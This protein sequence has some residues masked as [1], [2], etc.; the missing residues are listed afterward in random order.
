M[1]VGLYLI[2]NKEEN[3]MATN[4][5]IIYTGPVV[6]ADRVGQSIYRMFEP[7]GSYVDSNVF[8]NGYTNP[9]SVGDGNSYGKSVYATNVD[10][11]GSLPGLL[12]MASSV[13]RFA[14]FEQAIFAAKAAQDAGTT[15]E[16]I[17]FAVDGY[18][19]ELYWNQMAPNF[20]PQGFYIKVGDKEYGDDP[21][22]VP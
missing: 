22:S 16:G 6:D 19:E 9:G 5:Q 17:T 12:P 21:N 3:S 20:V 4:V 7:T 11:W 1:R 13:V 15:N 18:Q 8:E 10:G 2:H 14:E